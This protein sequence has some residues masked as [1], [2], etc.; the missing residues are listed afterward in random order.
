MRRAF[1]LTVVF[2]SCIT[3]F[4]ASSATQLSQRK[5]VK[6]FMQM[7]VKK[8]GFNQ[9]ELTRV[10]NDARIQPKIIA[11]MERPYEK[12]NWDVYKNLFLTQQRLAGGIDYWEQNK[13]ALEKAEKKYGVPSHVIVAVIGVETLY[14]TRKGSYRVLDA[15][16]TLAFDYPKRSVFF[17]K[18]L[19]EYLILCREN[20]IN[21]RELLGSYA[22][23][24][25]TPQFMPSSYRH[26]AVDFSGNGKKDIINNHEDAI[27]SVANYLSKHGWKHKR[28]VAQLAVVQKEK[29]PNVKFNAKEAAYSLEQLKQSGIKPRTAALNMPKKAGVIALDTDKGKEYWIAYPNFYVITRYNT[30]PQYALAVHLLSQQLK[31]RWQLAK[32]HTPHAYA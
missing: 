2:F 31:H 11:S 15:L 26:Y 18:E 19:A 30:S 25:G 22:G 7:M 10:F 3:C 21:P 8:H 5:D 23:A 14:G 6:A 24:M 28:G 29:K 16:T 1:L 32:Q 17:K 9:E 4:T 20:K 13:A 27:G 12:K